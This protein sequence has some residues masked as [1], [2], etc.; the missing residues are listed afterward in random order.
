MILRTGDEVFCLA[1]NCNLVQFSA[2]F[3]S[4]LPHIF[5]FFPAPCQKP[6]SKDVLL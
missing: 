1:Q 5:N 6:C 4:K 2:Q 3:S